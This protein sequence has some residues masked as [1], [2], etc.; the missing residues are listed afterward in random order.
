V[1]KNNPGRIAIIKR[2]SRFKK[3]LAR[4]TCQTQ[5]PSA[6]EQSVVFG[7]S[8]ACFRRRL[9]GRGLSMDASIERLASVARTH[10]PRCKSCRPLVRGNVRCFRQLQS[11]SRCA[12][13]QRSRSS[14][15]VFY[16]SGSDSSVGRVAI[17]PRE[18]FRSMAH[19][20]PRGR[21]ARSLMR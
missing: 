1:I 18:H 7:E 16:N 9:H 20:N 12:S 17:S 21:E 5:A 14:R 13:R 4:Q 3:I 10:P 19:L 15:A 11:L 8:R 2:R 6:D